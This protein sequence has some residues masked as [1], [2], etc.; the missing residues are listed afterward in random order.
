MSAIGEAVGKPGLQ[1]LTFS[2]EQVKNNLLEHGTPPAAANLL[3]ELGAA[4]H[5]GL[6]LGDYET[7]RPAPGKV[8]LPEFIKEFAAAYARL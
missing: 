6:L 1:W 4:L 2:D 3:T 8:K 7:H 5:S